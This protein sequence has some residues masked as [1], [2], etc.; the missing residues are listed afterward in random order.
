MQCDNDLKLPVISW[1]VNF[2]VFNV[3]IN[4]TSSID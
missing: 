3:I 4:N 2:L 1:K